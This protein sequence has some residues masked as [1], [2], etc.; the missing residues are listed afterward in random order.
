MKARY[1]F[2]N[3]FMADPSAHVFNDRIYIYPSHDSV[4]SGGKTWLRSLKLMPIDYDNEEIVL[5]VKTKPC[6]IL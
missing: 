1:I 3:D 5:N 6:T 4:P 2:P